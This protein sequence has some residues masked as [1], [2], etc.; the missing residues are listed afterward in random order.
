MRDPGLAAPVQ[1]FTLRRRPLPSRR[2]RFWRLLAALQTR[3]HFSLVP[4]SVSCLPSV[5][6]GFTPCLRRLPRSCPARRV[7]SFRSVPFDGFRRFS[8]D[9][10][11]CR[12]SPSSRPLVGPP[13]LTDRRAHGCHVSAFSFHPDAF[14]AHMLFGFLV[15]F[16]SSIFPIPAYIF[17]DIHITVIVKSSFA[18][19]HI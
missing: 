5:F 15:C 9:L 11:E 6:G 14:V 18:N 8:H 2:L 4:C 12:F 19:S 13:A 16:F 17:L 7:P 3:P 1:A 10:L